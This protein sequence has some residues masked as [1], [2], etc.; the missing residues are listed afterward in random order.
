MR[1]D[2]E[3]FS[4]GDVALT[5]AAQSDH[6][7]NLPLGGSP[8]ASTNLVRTTR[9]ANRKVRLPV[10][11]P[12]LVEDIRPFTP[13]AG[14]PKTRKDCPTDRHTRGCEYV[15]CR[16]HLWR[17]DSQDRA[18]RPSLG[19]VPRDEQGHTISAPGDLGEQFA[20]TTLIP[21][22]LDEMRTCYGWSYDGEITVNSEARWEMFAAHAGVVD[23]LHTMDRALLARARVDVDTLELDRALPGGTLA[24][25]FVRALPP[26][27]ALDQVDKHGTMTNE[28]VGDAIGRH[29]TL[30]AQIV[31]RGARKLKAMGVDLRDLVGE[32]DGH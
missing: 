7:L 24:L 6:Q 19:S 28:Q 25:T 3:T 13:K 31:K 4:T 27:C 16:A 9:T 30:V 12:D 15:K 5:R 2:Q 8:S 21:M 26:S 14:V 20:E 18:G 10:L 17:I 11:E 22:W 23:V 32:R 1:A 29:R